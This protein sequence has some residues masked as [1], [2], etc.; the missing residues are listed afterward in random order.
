MLHRDAAGCSVI[1]TL[2]GFISE[3]PSQGVPLVIDECRESCD[4]HK[5]SYFIMKI[6]QTKNTK[7]CVLASIL[8]SLKFKMIP[9]NVLT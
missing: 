7:I 2:L 5:V 9:T 4:D 6:F 1:N 3:T 8:V